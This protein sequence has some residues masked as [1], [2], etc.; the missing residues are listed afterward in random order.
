[1][2]V[3]GSIIAVAGVLF[4]LVLSVMFGSWYTVPDG[5]RG[6]ITRNNAV[7][8]LAEP[9]LGFK[10]PWIDGVTDMSVQT[11]RADF[12]N[13][14]AY[15]RDIQQSSNFVTVNYRLDAASVRRMYSEVGVDYAS[16]LLNARVFKHLKEAY[17]KFAAAEIVNRRDEVSNQIETA[18]REDMAEYGIIIDDVQLANIDFS[19]TYEKSIEEAA[20]AEAQVKKERQVLEQIKVS[21]LQQVEQANAKAQAIKAE[22]DANA[23]A[24]RV[25]GEAE[26]AAIAARGMA[27]RDNPDL[28]ALTAAE[29]WSGIL[30]T[31][32]VPNGAVPFLTLPTLADAR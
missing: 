20:M 21:A 8:G 18:L 15:S 32:M 14:E 9:G 23:Y 25:Q 29:R 3:R 4:L 31:S 30:P 22:A 1:M 17:G 2:I 13:M 10:L 12:E 27:L 28:I 5:Y 19:D 24:R 16:R 7:I 26:A 6:V 11:Q